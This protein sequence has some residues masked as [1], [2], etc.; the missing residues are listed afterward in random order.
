MTPQKPKSKFP[1]DEAAW[2]RIAASER[3][4]YLLAVKRAF[5]IPA[6]LFF[7]TYYL[8][9]PILVGYAPKLMS[10][11]IFGTVTLAYGY[12]ISQFAVGGIIALLYLIASARFD[13]LIRDVIA[14][15]AH[16][17]DVKREH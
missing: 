17:P 5:I 11:Q 6:F 1:L 9:L 4:R 10:K 14:N 3:F 15:E 16:K 13:Q 2:S 7:L 12:A 8:L